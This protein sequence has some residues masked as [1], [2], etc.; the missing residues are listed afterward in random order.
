MYRRILTLTTLT[1]LLLSLASWAEQN[2]WAIIDCTLPA[3]QGIA[4][5]DT[6]IVSATPVPTPAYCDVI[7]RR[8]EATTGDRATL[9]EN[10]QS[11]EDVAEQ[12]IG[13]PD[14]TKSNRGDQNPELPGVVSR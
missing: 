10:G 11:F 1:M 12:R 4:P 6:T 7:V 14:N 2:A 8:F 5:A 9:A 13:S 3:I